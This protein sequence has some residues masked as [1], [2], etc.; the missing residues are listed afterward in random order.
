MKSPFIYM[1]ID[2]RAIMNNTGNETE[3]DKA[4]FLLQWEL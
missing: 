1:V 2:F 4:D 3:P